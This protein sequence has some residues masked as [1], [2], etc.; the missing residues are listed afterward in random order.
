M[1]LSQEKPHHFTRN[2]NVLTVKC[3]KKV[4]LTVTWHYNDRQEWQTGMIAT[5]SNIKKDRELMSFKV[6]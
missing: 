6:T 5:N 4:H 3:E 2:V 1:L